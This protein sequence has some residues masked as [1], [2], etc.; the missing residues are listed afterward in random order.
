MENAHGVIDL[1]DKPK[2]IACNKAINHLEK[3]Q[4]LKVLLHKLANILLFSPLIILST[5]PLAS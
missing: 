5:T 4:Q 2:K 3:R 1:S